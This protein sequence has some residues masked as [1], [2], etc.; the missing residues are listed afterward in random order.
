M[1]PF[2]ERLAQKIDVPQQD[3]ITDALTD[4]GE[5]MRMWRFFKGDPRRSSVVGT[6]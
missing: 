2:T 1:H 5:V 3:F 4:A 6:F